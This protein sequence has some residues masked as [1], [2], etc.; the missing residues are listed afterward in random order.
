MKFTK[1]CWV[2]LAIMLA[3]LNEANAASLE[4]YAKLPQYE[5]V[6][7]SPDGKQLAF[8]TV[9]GDERQMVIQSLVEENKGS[10][11]SVGKEK[12]RALS[13]VSPDHL[14]FSSSL[15]TD[16]FTGS[17][18][19]LFR[20]DA[21]DLKRR[22][23]VNLYKFFKSMGPAL[24][25]VRNALPAP[26]DA[27]MAIGG[28]ARGSAGVF[29]LDFSHRSVAMLDAWNGR[30]DVVANWV[31]D[32]TGNLLA[33][34]TYDEEKQVWALS[35]L[36]D[37]EWSE[38]LSERTPL[39][40]PRMV[41]IGPEQGVIT[42]NRVKDGELIPTRVSLKDGQ[43]GE[44]LPKEFQGE[45]YFI[46]RKTRY[47]IGT[48]QYGSKRHY[49]F[50]DP[51]LQEKWDKLTQLFPGTE[52]ILKSWTDDWKKVVVQVFGIEAGAGYALVDT[53][54]N[55]FSYLGNLYSGIDA[56]ALSPMKAI[57]YE[58][59]DGLQISGY[60]TFPRSKLAKNMPLIVMPHGG[61]S[62]RDTLDF[63][64]LG[65]ALAA[66]GYLV[67][68]PNFRGS[69]ELGEK[70]KEA[71]YGE[72]GGKMQSDLSDGA[73]ALIKLGIADAKRVCI[74]GWSYGGYAALA[75][76]THESDLYRCAA[77]MA[78][79][80]DLKKLLYE[81]VSDR[82]IKDTRDLR[83]DLRY[84]GAKDLND[85]I[86]YERSPAFHVDKINIPIL[87]IHGDGDSVVPIEQS[88]IMAAALKKANKPYEF[89]K[90][91]SEDHWLSKAD[92]R[93]QMLQAVVKFLEKNNPP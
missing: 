64:W 36:K 50:F 73:R 31:V 53:S 86:L 33:R 83:N 79:I 44:A 81:H 59:S 55:S 11:V 26:T 7:I 61:P 25:T 8:I 76:A 37:G 51:G 15:S 52:V 1:G 82:R 90:L 93:L 49:V 23:T 4:A 88:V 16:F 65:Q 10:R 42:L 20:L 69:W 5:D 21:Y 66:K 63:D 77:S 70:F 17:Q 78:G 32:S 80:S 30:D 28:F 14:I 19:E 9:I 68:Q 13:W 67:L 34:A 43:W 18:A 22:E 92:T 75:G 54:D 58:A 39:D 89:V 87:L 45:R 35:I 57:S 72:W 56:A 38:V 27:G 2:S 84:V 74:F 48:L 62:S 41:G 46:D 85:P 12:L 29:W 3:F 6:S 24:S 71:G 40:E 47:L 60:L 91:K